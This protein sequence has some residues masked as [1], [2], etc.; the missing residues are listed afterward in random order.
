MAIGTAA[1]TPIS[2]GSETVAVEVVGR[3]RYLPQ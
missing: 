1:S 3:W 2:P